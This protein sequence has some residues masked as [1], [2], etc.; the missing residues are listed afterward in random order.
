MMVKPP[1]PPPVSDEKIRALLER[2]KCP[3]PFH[4]IRTRMLGSIA[5]PV[6]FVSPTKVVQSFWGGELPTFNSVDEANEL[7]GGLM[8]GLWNRLARHQNRNTPFRLMRA[9]T[10]PTRDGLAAVALMRCQ[11]LD[12]FVDG[13]FSGE[14]EVD[15][16]ERAHRGLTQLAEMRVMFAMVLRIAADPHIAG[17]ETEMGT[18]LPHLQS[19]THQAEREIQAIMI[20]CALAR[21]QSLASAAA[22]KPTWH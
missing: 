11:E 18:T 22:T 17:T 7:L 10:P 16:P 9:E 2:Y 19:T 5:T 1:N 3:V 21:R 8:M 20:A 6:A 15:L 12:G 14:V 4:E 13:L